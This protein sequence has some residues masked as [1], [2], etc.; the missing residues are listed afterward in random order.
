MMQAWDEFLLLQ[1]QDLGKETVNKWLRSLKVVRFDAGNLYLEAKDSFQSLWFEE[2]IRPKVLSQLVNNNHKKIRVHLTIANRNP[3][4]QKKKPLKSIPKNISRLSHPFH[5]HF[6]QL[7]PLCTFDHFHEIA[8]NTVPLEL[9]KNNLTEFNP[10]YI[11]GQSGSGKTHLAMAIA[12][13]QKL[14]GKRTLYVRAETFTDHVVAA[15]RAG[16]MGNF[17]GTY[18]NAE[19]LIIDDVHVFGRKGATQEEFFHTFNTLHLAGKQIILTSKCSP[20]ELIEVEMRLV[21]R[22]EWGIVLPIEAS[23]ETGLE[24]ILK[25]KAQSLNY[26]LHPKVAEFMIESFPSGAKAIMNALSALILRSH[27]S[28][29]LHGDSKPVFRPMT[30]QLAKHYLSDL[31]LV[32]KQQALTSE[33][34]IQ[35]SSDHFGIRPE[36]ILGKAQTRD[37]TQPRQIAMFL[38]RH[39]LKLPFN[40]IGD[41]FGRDHST[42]MS[43]V[44]L[45]QQSQEGREPELAAAIQEIEKKIGKG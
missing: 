38:C 19:V 43:S 29:N 13:S 23:K 34:I 40:T 1:E 35:A 33:K 28:Q 18:R 15:I 32:E 10:I 16:E 2:H 24:P 14:Q 17:R 31:L 5:L 44:R 20:S 22:F 7:D 11:W 3:Q 6:D 30:V 12:H 21:S 39:H 27:I 42:V 8:E 41:I 4:E 36:D 37:C 45:I 25:K 9:L 26:P